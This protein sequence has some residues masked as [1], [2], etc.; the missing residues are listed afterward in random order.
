MSECFLNKFIKDGEV[1]DSVEF[2]DELLKKNG[3]VYE[4]LRVIDGVPLFLEKHI[5]RMKNS[6]MLINKKFNLSEENIK[7]DIFKLVD[8]NNVQVGN[9]KLLVDTNNEKENLIVYFI[10]HAYPSAEMYKEGVVATLFFGERQNPN[11][12][13]VNYSFRD[14]VNEQI[15]INDAYEA[16]LVD[17]NENVTEGSRSNIFMVKDGVLIT[18]KVET[19]L[20]GVTR[21]SVI[22]IAKKC[23]IPL[24]ERE[25]NYKE[26]ETMDAVFMTGTSPK[27]LPIKKI[28]YNGNIIKL[29]SV[30]DEILIKLINKYND[31]I[32]EYVEKN[33]NS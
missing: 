8:V 6:F 4:V 1:R 30:N 24:E 18:S 11:A 33:K 9:V 32:K 31:E 21:G 20:P 13:V 14:N 15:K 22:S 19:V 23:E 2:N 16:I 7:K 25:I 17:R 26:L 3:I 10:K 29:R 28:I 27:L 5:S 12:K